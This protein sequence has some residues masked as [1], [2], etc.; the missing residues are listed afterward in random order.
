MSFNSRLSN[1]IPGYYAKIL[2]KVFLG[3]L[4][5]PDGRKKES[6][7]IKSSCMNLWLADQIV[8]TC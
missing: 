8:V 5:N 4:A 6:L 7:E 1:V 2:I 3:S